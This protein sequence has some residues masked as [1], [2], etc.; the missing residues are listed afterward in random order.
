MHL[1]EAKH[2]CILGGYIFNYIYIAP[3]HVT[4][5]HSHH[6]LFQG[7]ILQGYIVLRPVYGQLQ[8]FNCCA[9]NGFKEFMH[10]GSYPLML[11]AI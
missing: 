9:L 6:D 1:R 3:L 11:S 5:M 7:Q 8:Q 2:L 10:V 4:F